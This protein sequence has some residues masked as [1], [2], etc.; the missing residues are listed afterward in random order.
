MGYTEDRKRLD[1]SRGHRWGRIDDNAQGAESG[2][3]NQETTERRIADNTERTGRCYRN[4]EATEVGGSSTIQRGQT[5]AIGI[6]IQ[7]GGG[8][9]TI[10]E[11]GGR[12]GG[13]GPGG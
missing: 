6:K 11:S 1:G 2:N 13:G 5:D 4:Q 10:Q 3:R 12:R 7:R 9:L 8:T